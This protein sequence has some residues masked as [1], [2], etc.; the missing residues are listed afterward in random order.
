MSN[1]NA[2]SISAF[3]SLPNVSCTTERAVTG[4]LLPKLQL[5]YREENGHCKSDFVNLKLIA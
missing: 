1:C 5:A 4:M 3:G 2:R